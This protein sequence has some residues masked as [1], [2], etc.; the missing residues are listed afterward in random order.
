MSCEGLFPWDFGPKFKPFLPPP[1]DPLHPGYLKFNMAWLPILHHNPQAPFL[2]I[3]LEYDSS[4]LRQASYGSVP[5]RSSEV[6]PHFLPLITPHLPSP[7]SP[8]LPEQH[9]TKTALSAENLETPAGSD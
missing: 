8:Q 6:T 9:R 4:A 2:G 7:D 5:K 3:S 1:Q